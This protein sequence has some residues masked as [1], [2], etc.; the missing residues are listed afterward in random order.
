MNKEED[1]I[2]YDK[3]YDDGEGLKIVYPKDKK[4]K[5]NED[6]SFTEWMQ[7]LEENKG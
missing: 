7:N 2:R 1:K 3:F 6:I 5:N 4:S